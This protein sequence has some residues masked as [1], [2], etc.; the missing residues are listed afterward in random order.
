M[1]F[2]IPSN[3]C[4]TAER[5]DV[6]MSQ[7]SAAQVKELRDKTG[8]GMMTCK[9]ALAATD[10]DPV[11]AVEYLRK[12]GL[13]AANK[14]AGRA[15]SAGRI[16][17]YIHM[18][19]NLGVMVEVN[20]ESDFVA[21]GETFAQLVKDVCMHVAATDPIS[22]A[23]EDVPADVVAKEKEIYAEQVKGKPAEVIEK[24]VEGKLRKYY[25]ERCLLEQPFVKD[26]SKTVGDL[27][28]ETIAKLGENISVRRFARFQ[29]GEEL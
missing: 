26:T 6:D 21:R 16:G 15:T 4:G 24:I 11:K 1:D 10:G 20:C 18:T 8:L 2:G 27:V 12:K 25:E 23:S 14:R 9:E 28:K 7:I 17:S 5:E 13:D 3:G 22:V 29:L 19:G